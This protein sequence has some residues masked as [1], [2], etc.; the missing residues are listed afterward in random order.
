MAIKRITLIFLLLLTFSAF[1]SENYKWNNV[2][3]GGGGFVS[4]IITCPTQKNLIFAKTD[5]GGAY[6]WN[7]EQQSWIPLT[8]W[9][10]QNEIGYMGI[11]SIAIDPQSPNRVYM[12]AGLEYFSQTKPAIFYSDDYGDTFQKKEVSFMIHGNGDG[13]GTGERLIVDPNNSNILYFGSRKQGL[14]RST[15]MARSWAKV[16]SFPVTTTSNNVGVNAIVFD[17]SS[18]TPGDTSHTIFV[19]VSRIGSANLYVSNDAG[20]TWSPVDG[21]P[22][23]MAP[24]RMVITPDSNLL[25]TFA[26]GAGPYGNNTDG[27]NKGALFKYNIQA[28]TWADITP[29]KTTKP[30]LSGITFQLDN[31][32][33]LVTSTTNTWWA[34]NWATSATVYGDEIYRSTDGGATWANLFG[35][36]KTKLEKGEFEWANPKAVA[37]PL[38]LHW[39]TCIVLDPFNPERAFVNSGNGIFMTDNISASVSNWKFQVKGLDETVPNDIASPLYGAPL[40]SV[41]SDYDGFRHND[42]NS[43]P[44]LGRHNPAIGTTLTLDFAEKDPRIVARAGSAAYYSTD[45]AKKWKKLPVPITGANQGSIA[46]SADGKTILWC[47]KDGS[48]YSTTDYKT[49]VEAEDAPSNQRVIA[50]RENPLRF[51]IFANR[52]LYYSKDGGLTFSEGDENSSLNNVGKIRCAPGHEGDVW[53]PS[54]DYG[55]YRTT[56]TNG[57]PVHTKIDG[58]SKC[59]AVGF[60]KAAPDMSYPAIFIWGTI[61]KEEGLFRSDDEGSSWVRINDDDHEYGGP[62]NGDEVIGDPRIYGRV[63]MTT[64]GRGIVYGDLVDGPDADVVIDTE[65]FPGNVSSELKKRGD[66]ELFSLSPLDNG[67]KLT[68]SKAGIYS[69]YSVNGT[70]LE[71]GECNHSAIIGMNLDRDFMIVCFC[72]NDG[73]FGSM[74]FLK[75]F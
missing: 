32:N 20:K 31:P 30:A 38:S 64:P 68:S 13:R 15:D 5:M 70:L 47:P 17:P 12:A 54:R 60:G 34:Q 62:G 72:D 7:E 22:V 4:S 18:G 41:I 55:L 11:E 9:I 74:K 36:K 3:I 75:K 44:V 45:N 49:W 66:L 46:V 23:D 21:Y 67:I 24:Q 65:Y 56:W 26:N 57:A 39:A 8:D 53:I 35:K 19:G 16:A 58:P 1:S 52:T 40:L 10:N 59:E 33:I 51:Y 61:D 43:S 2:I 28:K 71:K 50:D 48:V 69:I 63:F 27:L 42:L 37:D 6:R 73:K 25:V 14:W 29:N